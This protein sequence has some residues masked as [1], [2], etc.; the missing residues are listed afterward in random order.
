MTWV[1]KN[2]TQDQATSLSDGKT[3]DLSGSEMNSQTQ[4]EGKILLLI[5]LTIY[6]I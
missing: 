6:T 1:P 4:D 5:K 3:E 2:R